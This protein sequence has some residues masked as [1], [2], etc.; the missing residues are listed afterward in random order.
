[1]EANKEQ[2]ECIKELKD[3]LDK[4]L[5][6][7]VISD[8][9]QEDR[10]LTYC[11]DTF[12]EMTGYQREEVIGRNCRFLQQDDRQQKGLDVL[13]EAI[14]NHEPCKVVLPNYKKNGELFL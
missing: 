3:V 12:L 4:S 11:N 14:K 10:P 9:R 7:A 2:Q 8:M 1:M 13:R 5:E 6:G